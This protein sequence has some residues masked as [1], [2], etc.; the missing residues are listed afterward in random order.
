MAKDEI[1]VRFPESVGLHPEQAW[2]THFNSQGYKRQVFKTKN[3]IFIKKTIDNDYLESLSQE[4]K[5]KEGDS[6]TFPLLGNQTDVISYAESFKKSFADQR[7]AILDFEGLFF[8]HYAQVANSI[9]AHYESLNLTNQ[10]DFSNKID[11][12]F[13]NFSNKCS[14]ITQEK[15]KECLKANTNAQGEIDVSGLNK[16]LNQEMAGLKEKLDE[17]FEQELVN[18]R[19]T[20]GTGDFR[21][22]TNAF[23]AN[24]TDIT[25][26]PMDDDSTFIEKIE[27]STVT[28]HDKHNGPALSKV[29][30]SIRNAGKTEKIVHQSYRTSH[31][32]SNPIDRRWLGLSVAAVIGI[33]GYVGY[34]IATCMMA[35][36]AI[37]FPPLGLAL[38]AIGVVCLLKIAYD[39]WNHA[40]KMEKN[41]EKT[42]NI[43]TQFISKKG[44]RENPIIYNLYTSTHASEISLAGIADFFDNQQTQRLETLINAQHRH[45]SGQQ[46]IS[47]MFFTL[48]TPTNTFGKEI[49]LKEFSSQPDMLLVAQSNLIALAILLYGHQHNQVKS[50]VNA[51][52]NK[53]NKGFTNAYDQLKDIEPPKLVDQKKQQAL[54]FLYERF[55]SDDAAHHQNAKTTA[56]CVGVLSHGKVNLIE[57]CKSG[58]ERTGGI[59]GRIATFFSSI[60]NSILSSLDKTY[61]DTRCNSSAVTTVSR[62]DQGSD[63]KTGC[64]KEGEWNYNTNK[65]EDASMTNIQTSGVINLQSHNDNSFSNISSSETQERIMTRPLTGPL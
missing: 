40:K 29:T 31:L 25:E 14:Q 30:M 23:N 41:I 15:F 35:S 64:K 27:S 62:L 13:G 26:T 50:M 57:G 10:P 65:T 22:I 19:I 58:N 3:G 53:N 33:A 46:F 20:R 59:L 63:P 60:G 51:Y 55:K 54:D 48:N 18:R 1:Q 34:T 2:L 12:V 5:P 24:V 61:N 9:K 42:Q 16:R 21:K 4:K 47:N 17:D 38:A 8:Y 37:S 45:N 36:A 28:A 11:E 52:I 6:E 39:W 32:V 43:I 7:L 56:T 44:D 49:S